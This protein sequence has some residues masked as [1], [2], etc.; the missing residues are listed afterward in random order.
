[1]KKTV[2]TLMVLCLCIGSVFLI[3]CMCTTLWKTSGKAAAVAA[4]DL[5]QLDKVSVRVSVDNSGTFPQSLAM[6]EMKKF[7]ER[8]SDGKIQVKVFTNGQLGSEDTVLQQVQDGALEMC[9]ASIAP[10]TTYQK[11]FSVLDIP[12]LFENYQQA[13]MVLDSTVGQGILGTLDEVG[14]KGL[15]W[16]ENGFRHVTTSNRRIESLSDLKGLKIRTMS[17]ANHMLDFQALGANPTP[18]SYSEL[19]MALSQNIVEGQENPLANVWDANMFEVQRYVIMTGHIY[20]SLPLVCNLNWWND[21]PAEY[22]TILQKGAMIA[23]NYSRFCNK[24]RE[25]LLRAKLTEKGMEFVDLSEAARTEMKNASQG[26]VVEA[27]ED[28]LGQEY[29]EQFLNGIDQVLGDVG[30]GVE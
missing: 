16:M 13:W 23:Q 20:D 9:T 29:V 11:K 26:V 1:M 19:Y 10:I 8:E 12:F 3:L 21:L 14:L 6:Y 24:Q 28:A 7:V 30:K 22:R 4:D 27:V 18:V 2:T 17:A 15:A 25:A 5:S